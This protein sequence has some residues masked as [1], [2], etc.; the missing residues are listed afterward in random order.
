M[1]KPNVRVADIEAAIW[2]APLTHRIVIVSRT[3]EVL[4]SNVVGGSDQ[5]RWLVM[6]AREHVAK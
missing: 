1:T 2:A 3:G 5:F 4:D 6:A